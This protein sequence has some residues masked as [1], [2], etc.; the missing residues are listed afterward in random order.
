MRLPAVLDGFD[1]GF[2]RGLKLGEIADTRRKVEDEPKDLKDIKDEPRDVKIK[3]KKAR[4]RWLWFGLVGA[5]VIDR[6][7]LS[8]DGDLDYVHVHPVYRT[9]FLADGTLNLMYI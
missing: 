5:L 4:R 3:K 9:F 6:R 1:R 7:N 8:R 2:D